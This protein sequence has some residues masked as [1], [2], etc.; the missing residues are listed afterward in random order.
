MVQLKRKAKINNNRVKSHACS[1][2]QKIHVVTYFFVA[3]D[4]LFKLHDKISFANNLYEF[5][6]LVAI[7]FR[8]GQTFLQ[9]CFKINVIFGH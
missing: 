5:I 7:K 2:P 9:T 8:F 1:L 4:K 6:D 3:S